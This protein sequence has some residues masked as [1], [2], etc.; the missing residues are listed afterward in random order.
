MGGGGG[1]LARETFRL[2][3]ADRMTGY[4]TDQSEEGQAGRL[5]E[6]PLCF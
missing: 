5:E 3:G 6:N 1:G 2:E 4:R